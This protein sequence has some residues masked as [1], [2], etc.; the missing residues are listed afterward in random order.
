[1]FR[2]DY[3][4]HRSYAC[5]K[6]YLCLRYFAHMSCTR[7]KNIVLVLISCMRQGNVLHPDIEHVCAFEDK[8]RMS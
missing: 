8:V 2:S 5:N 4:G 6:C 3:T 1:M 7:L